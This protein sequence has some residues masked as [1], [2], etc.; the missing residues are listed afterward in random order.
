[1]PQHSPLVVGNGN[2]QL[3][4][5]VNY[6]QALKIQDLLPPKDVAGEET[7]SRVGL[8]QGLQRDFIASHAGMAPL[9]HQSAYDRAIKLMRMAGKKAFDLEQE[10]ASVRDRYGRTLFGQGCLL[11]RRLIERGVPFV[12]VTLFNAPGVPNGTGW[13]THYQNFDYVQKLSAVLDPAWSALM[14]DL[15]ARGLLDSTLIVWMGEFGRTPKITPERGRDHFPTA[16]TTVLAGGGIK[17]GQ[18]VGRTSKDGNVVEER[19]VL[20][21]DF[22]A[23]ICLA[24]GIDPMKQ[25]PSNVGRPIRIADPTAKPIKEVLA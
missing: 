19:P 3:Q 12:E 24:L 23:T 5:N 14:D 22:L 16:W 21:P 9:S 11:A 10:P 18:V 8:L 4:D 6:D 15:Q 2:L 17:G 7:D 25:N 20:I 1:G 13:D